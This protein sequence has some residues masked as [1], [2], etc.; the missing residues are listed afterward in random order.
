MRK[1]PLYP[2]QYA[3]RKKNYVTCVSNL[4][5]IYTT[6]NNNSIKEKNNYSSNHL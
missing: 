1:T 3:S 2:Y 6:T 5:H 4:I